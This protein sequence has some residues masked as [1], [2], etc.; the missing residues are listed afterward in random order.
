MKRH[1]A[2]PPGRASQPVNAECLRCVRSNIPM[3]PSHKSLFCGLSGGVR[4]SVH[5]VFEPNSYYTSEGVPSEGAMRT[6]VVMVAVLVALGLAT[7]GVVAARNGSLPA[8]STPPD[9]PFDEAKIALPAR[10]SPVRE[11]QGSTIIPADPAPPSAPTSIAPRA[12][13]RSRLAQQ[14]A[15]VIVQRSDSHGLLP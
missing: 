10:G 1:S 6:I 8:L 11:V 9:V 12:G 14:L 13:K 3:W 5:F 2:G 7:I 4:V 15:S